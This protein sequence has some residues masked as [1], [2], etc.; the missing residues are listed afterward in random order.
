MKRATMTYIIKHTSLLLTTLFISS[1]YGQQKIGQHKILQSINQKKLT[2]TAHPIVL[3]QKKFASTSSYRAPETVDFNINGICNLNCKWC[4]GPVHNAKEDVS[5]SEWKNL[6]YKLSKLGTRNVVF[7]GGETLL[8]K[9]LPELARYVNSE[10]GMRTTLSSNGLLMLRRGPSV[11]PHVND[12]GL[13]IDG[14]NVEINSIM[15]KGT[16][17]HFSKVL[18]AIKF[19]QGSFSN[20]NLTARTV[21]ATP[22]IESVPLIG[23]TLL[24]AGV[25]PLKLRWKLYQVSPVGPRKSEILNGDLLITKKQFEETVA[26]TKVLNPSFSIEA[27]PYENSFGRYFHVFPDGKS[28]IVTQGQDGLPHELEMGNIVKDFDSVI[29]KV[30]ETFDFAHNSKHGKN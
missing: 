17:L 16:I 11:L 19:V 9:E 1:C 20:V 26:K 28:H 29:Q 7:T 23:E 12:L 18:E 14:H 6:A 5:L 3:Q 8:K 30:N 10:L 2:P 25:D 21:V 27:Q 13:P 4:W 22:N 24:N 15:R